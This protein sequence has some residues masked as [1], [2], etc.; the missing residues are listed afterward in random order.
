MNAKLGV[1]HLTRL[2]L[3]MKGGD[4]RAAEQIYN[5]LVSKVF[6]FC[7]SRLGRR[8][9]AED[10]TQDMFLKLVE[11]IELFDEQKGTF[12]VWFWNIARNTLTD[13]YRE[14]KES[15][16][17]DFAEEE[18]DRAIVSHNDS[19]IEYGN[20]ITFV[21]GLSADEKNLFEL[22]YVADLPYAEIAKI[23][24]KSAGALRVSTNRLRQKIKDEF[25]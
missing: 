19:H 12:V 11:K 17:A 1:D 18:L 21:G 13:Y 24:G 3:R 23:S 10:L 25:K 4:A 8:E 20:L 5:E 14:K 16:F 22:R 15:S 6:G 9:L 7:M 2:A